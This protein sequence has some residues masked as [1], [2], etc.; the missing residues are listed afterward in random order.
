MS[1]FRSSWIIRGAI[2]GLW[3]FIIAGFLWAPALVRA[4]FPDSSLKLLV[5]PTMIDAHALRAF[6][7]ATGTRVHLTYYESN[8]ELLRKLR[9][10]KAVG[11]D[12]IVAS[13]Y[14]VDILMQE[15]LLKPLAHEKFTFFNEL[16]PTLLNH[17]FDP[18]N[19]YSIPYYFGVYGLGID[20]NYF[21]NHQ[22]EA[23]WSLLFEPRDYR[24]TMT[25]DPRRA[26]LLAGNYLFGGIQNLNTP[27]HLQQIK[28][29]LLNQK[30]SV[31]L[32][33]DIR[34]EET[35]AARSC[36]VALTISAD[37]WR[38]KQEY[39]DL[40][41]KIPQEGSFM[42]IDS[43]VISHATTQEDQVYQLLN[44][45]YSPD[46]LKRH[47]TKYGFCPPRKTIKVAG[48]DLLCPDEELLKKLQF[49]RNVI[50][51]VE[52]DQLWIS[53]MSK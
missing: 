29:L 13:D 42:T 9:S 22:P 40:V 26:V 17:Y 47:A 24:V 6:E 41:F 30:R 44:F 11:Y 20:T 35:L 38:I 16:Y 34:G 52:I 21:G 45:L 31:E 27:E 3:V 4:V 15:Q 8:E 28:Q 33:S 25:D 36:P 50:P 32:Y 46:I 12:L 10:T 48:Y 51:K 53:V 43:F 7:Q 49:F 39:K 18:G 5:L 37:L 23:S 19:R 1:S 14:V 2:V